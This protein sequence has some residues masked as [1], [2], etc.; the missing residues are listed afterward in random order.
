[1][2]DEVVVRWG[3][4]IGSHG[5]DV[6]SVNIKTGDVTLWDAKFRSNAVRVQPS[7]TFTKT[8]RLN[9]ALGE[10]IETLEANASLP[11]NIKQQALD[12]LELQIVRTRT[13]GMGNAKNSTLR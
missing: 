5:S 8:P 7:Q 4:T 2:P 9:N 10:A 3:D 11:A 13:V 6:I 1:M 12:N